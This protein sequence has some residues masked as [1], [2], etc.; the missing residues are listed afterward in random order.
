VKFFAVK[1]KNSW[2][3]KQSIMVQNIDTIFSE[4]YSKNVASFEQKFPIN[5]LKNL[6]LILTYSRTLWK[7]TDR[8]KKIT[9]LY[10]PGIFIIKFWTTFFFKN[11]LQILPKWAQ[12]SV[13]KKSC[14]FKNTK[15]SEQM[16]LNYPFLRYTSRHSSLHSYLV[17]SRFIHWLC[18]NISQ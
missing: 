6:F 7:S 15:V 12:T 13:S 2:R 3:M 1:W 8:Q 16:S 9:K 11:I 18:E 4:C 10:S 5:K 14:C 17:F